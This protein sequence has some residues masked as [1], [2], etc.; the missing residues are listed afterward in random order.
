[1]QHAAGRPHPLIGTSVRVTAAQIN[2]IGMPWLMIEDPSS[3]PD[4]RIKRGSISAL[5]YVP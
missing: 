2:L 5:D 3:A 1:L 4:R